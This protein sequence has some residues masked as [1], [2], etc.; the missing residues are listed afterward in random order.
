[1]LSEESD[2]PEPYDV[3]VV[4]AGPGGYVAAIRARQL[5]LRTAI[6]EGRYWG[7]VCLNVGCIPSKALLRNA[8]L[9]HLLRERA[10]T[11]GIGIEGG[12][13]FTFDY[14]PAFR[15]SREVADARA[16]GV[17]YLM[18]KNQVDV[19]DGW[20]TFTGPGDL[21]VALV[22]G[23]EERLAFR[24]AIVATGA[25]ARRIPGWP[26]SDRVVTYEEQ[27]LA[28][29]PPASL[30]IVG[31]GAIGVEFAYLLSAFGTKVTIVEMLDRLLPLEDEEVSAELRRRFLRQGIQVV[32]GARVDAVEDTGGAVRVTLTTGDGKTETLEA[33]RL[34]TAVGFAPRTQGY[35][36]DT[37]GVEL[38]PRGAIGV[39][40]RMRTNVRHIYAIGDV[41]GRLMLAHVAE[42][43]AFVAAETIAGAPTV[44]LDFDMMPRAIYCQPQVA[45]FGYTEAQAL[46][47]GY[48]V[49]VARFPFNV[50]GKANG[51]GETVGFVKLVSDKTDGELLGAH[52]IGPEVTELLPELT[53]AR[54]GELT[55]AEIARNVH[56][57]PTL[58]EVIKDAAHGL[59]GH[60]INL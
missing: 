53:L 37:T 60:M 25:R 29:R 23:G 7:G 21:K 33:E 31:G 49:N 11:F 30:V 17:R 19:Y 39:D 20:A 42:A 47:K 52:M 38:T 27:I 44:A 26:V 57:H 2:M 55:V 45:S 32:T 6:V 51:L 18:R 14:A 1:V 35:G 46:E 9:V 22:A 58:S 59:L 50:N 34:L 5:G 54:A 13:R 24:N 15:R 40:E 3:V 8:E 12:G 48:S 10:D 56:A 4:G 36:L 41:T 28:E 43:M 16:K